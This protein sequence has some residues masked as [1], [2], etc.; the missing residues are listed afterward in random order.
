MGFLSG[1]RLRLKVCIAFNK[2]LKKIRSKMSDD[3]VINDLQDRAISLWKLCLRD[4]SAKLSS[5]LGNRCRQIEKNNMII[6]LSPINAVDHLMTIMDVDDSKSYLYEVRITQKMSQIITKLFDNENERR[7]R[8][9]E[10]E[11]RSFIFNDIDKLYKEIKS[12][13]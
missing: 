3:E 12:T 10:E 8:L 1:K 9:G 13:I 6:V 2:F 7:M 11:R 5:S 4:K